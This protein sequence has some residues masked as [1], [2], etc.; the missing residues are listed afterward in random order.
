MKYLYDFECAKESLSIPTELEAAI[1]GNRREGRRPSYGWVG[2]PSML[3][4]S[5][6]AE[7]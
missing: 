5:N 7:R 3:Q 6:V 4:A 1:E 2:S